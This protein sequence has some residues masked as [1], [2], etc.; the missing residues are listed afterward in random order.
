MKPFPYW[1]NIT[2][3]KYGNVGTFR[4]RAPK[5]ER[6]RI[7]DKLKE[8]RYLTKKQKLINKTDG[9]CCYC[10]KSVMGFYQ[11]TIEHVWPRAEGGKN[12]I[13]NLMPACPRCNSQRPNNILGADWAISKGFFEFVDILREIEKNR[14]I[15]DLHI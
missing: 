8:F 9:R 4:R 12:N 5:T 7:K 14:I 6:E 15:K 10:G 3:V 13:E 1:E 11:F 2:P